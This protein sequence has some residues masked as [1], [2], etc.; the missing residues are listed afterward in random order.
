MIV[1]DASALV[2]IGLQEPG[3]ERLLEA[4]LAADAVRAAPINLVETGLILSSRL[5]AFNPVGF[6]AWLGNFRILEDRDIGMAEVLTAYMKFGKGHH[7]AR[8]NLGACFAYALARRLDAPLLYKGDDFPQ[9]DVR[10]A[11]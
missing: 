3:F 1:V 6:E 4:L 7:P 9:T 10:S 11:I 5:Q 8:L 2:A